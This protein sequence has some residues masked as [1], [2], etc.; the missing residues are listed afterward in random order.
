MLDECSERAGVEELGASI[1]DRQVSLIALET[2][3]QRDVSRDREYADR[4]SVM[5]NQMNVLA[6]PDGGTVGGNRGKL[7]V[8][9]G[10]SLMHL[11]DVELDHRVA[12]VFAHEIEKEVSDDVFP[13]HA[14]EF[15]TRLVGIREVSVHVGAVNDVDCVFD[16][17]LVE[18]AAERL[19]ARCHCL[20]KL[21]CILLSG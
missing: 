15:F 3:A 14:K 7:V 18:I 1:A 16:Q 9:Y 4:P 8:G 19:N 17:H 11:A 12:E 2:L 13:G 20:R 5:L 6:E 10:N 21:G